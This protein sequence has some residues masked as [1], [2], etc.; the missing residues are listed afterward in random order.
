MNHLSETSKCGY[1]AIIGRPNVGKSTLLNYILKQKI[2]ITSHKPQ[3]TRHQILGIQTNGDVQTVYVDTPGLHRKA[4]QAINRYMNRAAINTLEMVDVVG[5]VVEALRWTDEDE[6]ILK[7]IK[8]SQLPVILIVNKVDQVKVKAELLPYLQ[9]LSEKMSF[10]SVVPVSAQ[11]GDNLT[12]L[13]NVIAEHLPHNPHLFS[14]DQITD[15]S[16]RFLASEL[17]REKIMRLVHQEVPY[18]VAVEIEEFK[19]KNKILH[20]T[21][22]IWLERPG[23]K[24]IVI[25]EGGQQLKQIGKQARIAMEKLFE[26]KIFLQL[27]VKVKSG[28]SDNER[29]L[30][31]FGYES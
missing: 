29:V 31:S 14:E 3:T 27:W 18:G 6:W 17:I 30:K 2:S 20:I 4:P 12:A 24:A 22:L 10:V 7:K 11:K 21:A 8:S 26:Q 9:K 28:W 16:D 15:R 1:V 13:E 25:G 19:V 23:Q 5:F